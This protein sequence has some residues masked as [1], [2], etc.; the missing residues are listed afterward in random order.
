MIQSL[1]VYKKNEVLLNKGKNPK[2]ETLKNRFLD[3]KKLPIYDFHRKLDI[4][5]VF[6][7]A[8]IHLCYIVQ[9]YD[10]YVHNNIAR[11]II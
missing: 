7:K 6:E 11:L 8:I 9:V 2:N 10:M 4:R 3:A 1:Y 5:V